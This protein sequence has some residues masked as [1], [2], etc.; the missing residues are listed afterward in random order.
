MATDDKSN[1]DLETVEAS[2]QP[3]LEYISHP[4][5]RNMTVTYLVT[6][7]LIICIV[8]VWLISFSIL[9]TALGILILFGSLAGFYFPTRYIFYGDHFL[10]K[11]KMQTLRKE[12]KQYRSFYPDKNGV[13]LSP[14]GR[15]TRMENFRGIYVKFAGN[16][17]KVLELVK[18]KIKTPEDV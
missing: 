11:S 6:I 13:L 12:W 4:A 2:Q 8:L 9:L 14:F 16:K 5:K 7:F 18:S 10:I 17:D 3:L 15:P 1:T